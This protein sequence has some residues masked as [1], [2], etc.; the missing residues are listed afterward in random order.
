MEKCPIFCIKYTVK[1]LVSDHLAGIQIACEQ[2]L[3][4]RARGRVLAR[5]AS[6]A[7]IGEL[8]RRLEFK[9][10]SQLELAAFTNFAC[11]HNIKLLWAGY[12]Y[13]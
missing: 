1:V 3:L 8:A 5:L 12:S 2:A 4:A 11:D 7:Q 6:L 10:W 13:N 9:K